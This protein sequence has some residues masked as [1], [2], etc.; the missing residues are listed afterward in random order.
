MEHGGEGVIALTVDDLAAF[1]NAHGFDGGQVARTLSAYNAL[2]RGGWET[3]VTPRT[4]S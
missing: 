4:E 1:A 3:L 2:A